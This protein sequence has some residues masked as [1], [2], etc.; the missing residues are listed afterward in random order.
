MIP[1]KEIRSLF[2]LLRDLQ[3]SDYV[4]I[5]FVSTFERQ[6]LCLRLLCLNSLGRMNSG[7]VFCVDKLSTDA[8]DIFVL[9]ERNVFPTWV[10][11]TTIKK[12]DI[13]KTGLLYQNHLQV[14]AKII[15]LDMALVSKD[16]LQSSQMHIIQLNSC[17]VKRP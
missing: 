14:F 3:C 1:V 10:I 5:Y 2:T 6:M 17:D 15:T 7:L 13:F 12:I 8:V 9:E 11:L 4:F 16:I